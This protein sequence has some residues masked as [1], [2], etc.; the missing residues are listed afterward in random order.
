MTNIQRSIQRLASNSSKKK[1]LTD[2]KPEKINGQSGLMTW[3]QEKASSTGSSAAIQPQHEN[4]PPEYA[5]IRVDPDIDRPLSCYSGF[6][7]EGYKPRFRVLGVIANPRDCERLISGEWVQ[8]SGDDSWWPNSNPE[9]TETERTTWLYAR[10]RYSWA[11]EPDGCARRIRAS[12]STS[13]RTSSWERNRALPV[14]NENGS[15]D[16]MAGRNLYG[17]YWT[18]RG[19]NEV[20]LG[21]SARLFYRVNGGASPSHVRVSNAS[22]GGATWLTAPGGWCPDKPVSNR[23]GHWT[24]SYTHGGG[25]VS[26]SYESTLNLA[27][28]RVDV[29]R[30]IDVRQNSNTTHLERYFETPRRQGIS[31]GMV[32]LP[33]S[34]AGRDA[35]SDN[36]TNRRVA[37]L[38]GN[39]T[40]RDRIFINGLQ[41]DFTQISERIHSEG[42]I[43]QPANPNF[44]F[45]RFFV[46]AVWRRSGAVIGVFGR[47]Q[48]ELNSFQRKTFYFGVCY[49]V[50][51][52]NFIEVKQDL[53]SNFMLNGLP[54]RQERERARDRFFDLHKY[55]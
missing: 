14:L 10:T 40:S 48:D 31:G 17:G 50:Q 11:G 28:T 38:P 36:Y 2:K 22:S 23:G 54:R 41:V 12:R 1:S 34:A 44:Y 52:N 9:R 8:V 15:T 53:L 20:D 16:F 29:R 27:G 24:T 43:E 26:M 7:A 25:A 35:N 13:P 3:P 49:S 51:K 39:T 30:V 32:P 37:L 6:V 55:L 4:K 47:F 45:Q 18:V 5:Q 33:T 42:L 19:E 46:N 21:N